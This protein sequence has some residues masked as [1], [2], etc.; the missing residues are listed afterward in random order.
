MAEL[1]KA[2]SLGKLNSK[3][4]SG[5]GLPAEAVAVVDP[6]VTSEEVPCPFV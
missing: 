6:P 3:G 4:S 1:L 2:A 5:V